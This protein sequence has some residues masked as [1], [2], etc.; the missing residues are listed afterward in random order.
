VKKASVWKDFFA[1]ERSRESTMKK[2]SNL[3]F[4][5]YKSSLILPKLI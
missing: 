1:L 2:L 4:S 3:G 5:L